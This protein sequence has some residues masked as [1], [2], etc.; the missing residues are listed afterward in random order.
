MVTVTDSKHG[1]ELR[2]EVHER[3][4]AREAFGHPFSYAAWR[5]VETP[6]TNVELN[7]VAA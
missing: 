3:E 5:G 6:S 2:F 1:D 4:R 7:E